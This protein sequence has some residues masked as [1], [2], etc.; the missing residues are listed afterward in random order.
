MVLNKNLFRR[1][2][3]KLPENHR[4]TWEE[5]VE[6][7][8]ALTL[9]RNRDGQ[10][11]Q[12]GLGFNIYPEELESWGF[13]YTEGT[14][15]LSEDGTECLFDSPATR[16]GVQ[17]LHDLVHKYRVALPRS[18]SMQQYQTW[19]L[20]VNEWK[21]AASCQGT[22]AVRA[23]SSRNER[24]RENVPDP[25]TTTLRSPR[26]QVMD[27]DVALF[28]SPATKMSVLSSAGVGHITIFKQMDERKRRLCMEL[29]KAITEGQGQQILEEYSLF[30]TRRSAGNIYEEGSILAG[31]QPYVTVAQVHRMHPD[32]VNIDRILSKELQLAV[33]GAKPIDEA[34]RDGDRKVQRLLDRYQERSRPVE[35]DNVSAGSGQEEGED[36][37]N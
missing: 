25:S 2:R 18:G 27:F 11:E 13:L 12:Y 34:V 10:P 37:W 29:A 20:F 21:F 36:S 30:P 8:Q 33:L 1:A 23:L 26:E 5:F 32:W 17:K 4:W 35:S 31:L 19:N 9:D 3:V 6:K 16:R 28:P 7:M 15:I 14:E 22:W 24:I